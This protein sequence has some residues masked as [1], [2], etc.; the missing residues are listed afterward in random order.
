MNHHSQ[1]LHLILAPVWVCVCAY[2]GSTGF[3]I[4]QEISWSM[5]LRR[6][7]KPEESYRVPFWLVVV[8]YCLLFLL[9]SFASS[10][11]S[12]FSSDTLSFWVPLACLLC[13][14]GPK[15]DLWFLSST[16]CSSGLLRDSGKT[17]VERALQAQVDNVLEG[18][19]MN[20]C[21]SVCVYV[22]M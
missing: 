15:R 4:S 7:T 18:T 17:A 3:E 2:V 1:A 8:L 20:L 14:R 9:F 19:H 10:S 13:P 12:S 22:C 16:S 6:R 11:P 5:T 21:I